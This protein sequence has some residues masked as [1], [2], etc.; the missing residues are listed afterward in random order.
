[1]NST[2]KQDKSEVP[3]KFFI[4]P[5]LVDNLINIYNSQVNDLMSMASGKCNPEELK[6]AMARTGGIQQAIYYLI[7]NMTEESKHG[8]RQTIRGGFGAFTG[9]V[10]PTGEGSEDRGTP[11]STG[12]SQNPQPADGNLQSPQPKPQDP[13]KWRFRKH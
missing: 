1:M 2:K 10:S 11:V 8:L 4:E 3:K 9:G 12:S 6:Y 5:E 13:R 7:N